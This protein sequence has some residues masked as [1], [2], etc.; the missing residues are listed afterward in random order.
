MRNVIAFAALFVVISLQ[1]LRWTR[2]LNSTR[3]LRLRLVRFRPI[4]IFMI[5]RSLKSK[6]A[7][8][9]ELHETL[10]VEIFYFG[11]TN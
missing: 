7:V 11:A 8:V 6:R 1:R 4:A 5:L 10:F 3:G 9:F 2:V